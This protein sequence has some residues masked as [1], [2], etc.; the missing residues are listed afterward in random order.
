MIC[1]VGRAARAASTFMIVMVA[2]G[3]GCRTPAALEAPEPITSGRCPID[4]VLVPAGA[5]T[6]GDGVAQCGASRHTVSITRGFHLGR[7]EVTNQE[8]LEAVRWACRHGYVS[9]TAVSVRD[10]LDGS[11]V[12]LLDLDDDDCEIAFSDGEFSLR[13][14]GHGINPDHP[15]KRVSWYGAARFCDWLSLQEELPRAYKHDGD[16][17][18]NGGDPYDARGYRLPTDAEWE[19]AAQYDDGRLYP[20]GYRAPGTD[21]LNCCREVGWTTPVGSYPPA[22]ASLGL[23]DMAGNAWEYCNDWHEC[24]LGDT[25]VTDPAGPR[26]GIGRVVRGGSWMRYRDVFRRASRFCGAPS[27]GSDHFAFRVARTMTR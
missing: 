13:D 16:W 22:P 25:A 7:H 10:S 15:V 27:G 26:S 3:L 18:C 8:Y 17:A 1:P 4:M 12:E 11:S 20:W 9:V 2:T 24:S 19:Y 5:F 14:A 23:E 6:M 21:L